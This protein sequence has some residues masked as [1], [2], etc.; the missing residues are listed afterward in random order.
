[1]KLKYDSI[2]IAHKLYFSNPL[3]VELALPQVALYEPVPLLAGET[4][5]LEVGPVQVQED[6]GEH[7][8]VVGQEQMVHGFFCE[9]GNASSERAR[10]ST[11]SR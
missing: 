11:E 2:Q 5:V 1:M 3:P 4:G 7:E 10:I 9:A 6:L 8:V